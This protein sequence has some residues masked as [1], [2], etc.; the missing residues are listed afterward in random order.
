M[1]FK[2]SKHVEVLKW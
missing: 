2:E 1:I